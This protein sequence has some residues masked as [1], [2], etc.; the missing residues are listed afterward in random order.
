M[1]K[2]DALKLQVGDQICLKHNLGCGMITEVLIEEDP[3]IPGRYPMIRYDAGGG[4]LLLCTHR[5]IDTITPKLRSV[6]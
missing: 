1:N 3:L 5:V 2:R 6:T 4:L